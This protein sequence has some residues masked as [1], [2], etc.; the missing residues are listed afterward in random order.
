MSGRIYL[1]CLWLAL[2][3]PTAVA[4]DTVQETIPKGTVVHVR[5]M[6]DINSQTAKVGDRVQVRVDSNDRSGLP[7]DAVLEGR[8]TEVQRARSSKPGILDLS[9][10]SLDWNGQ[11]QSISG[12]LY[13]LS[14]S[15]VRETSSGRL[16]AT[17][18]S[19]DKT[20]FLGYGALGGV[21]LGKVLGTSSLQGALLGAAAGYVYGQSRGGKNHDIDLKE[22][23]EFGVRLNRRLA[24]NGL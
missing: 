22:G 2:A 17:K 14:Q 12:D 13:S 5:L 24:L 7:R 15:D 20:K 10:D 23:S 19:G 18:R 21:V 4:A 1:S 8:V 6:D 9:F 11:R 3:L 16:I